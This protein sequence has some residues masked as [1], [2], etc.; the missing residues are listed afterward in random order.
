MSAAV[1]SMTTDAI[2]GTPMPAAGVAADGRSIRYAS[3]LVN[4]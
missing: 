1:T 4:T 3:E 2:W